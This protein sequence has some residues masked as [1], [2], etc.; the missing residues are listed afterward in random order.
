VICDHHFEY[1][2]QFILRTPYEHNRQN[3]YWN[4]AIA[5]DMLKLL[6]LGMLSL[7]GYAHGI[8]IDH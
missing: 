2:E 4:S 3:I 7:V 8:E 6:P 5:K 1:L